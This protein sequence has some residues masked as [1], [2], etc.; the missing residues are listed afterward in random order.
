[1]RRFAGMPDCFDSVAL[2]T[3][4]RLPPY[5]NDPTYINDTIRREHSPPTPPRAF[6]TRR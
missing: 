2:R 5:L 6:I 4:L 1:M 3:T